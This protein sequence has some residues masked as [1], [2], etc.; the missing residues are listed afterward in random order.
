MLQ[1]SC[2]SG[3]ASHMSIKIADQHIV[4]CPLSPV[5]CQVQD[6]TEFPS[7]ATNPIT[8]HP[9]P[10]LAQHLAIAQGYPYCQMLGLMFCDLSDCRLTAGLAYFEVYFVVFECVCALERNWMV[11]ESQ[12]QP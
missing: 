3:H 8:Q 1:D 4:A 7:L 10:E 12:M 11:L 2:A 6:E 5:I 9:Q